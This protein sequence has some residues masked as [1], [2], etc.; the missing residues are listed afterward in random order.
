MNAAKGWRHWKTAP[1]LQ[2]KGCL[3]EDCPLMCASR[4]SSGQCCPGSCRSSRVGP[5]LKTSRIL[6][7]CWQG[8]KMIFLVVNWRE[9]DLWLL[10]LEKSI[11]LPCLSFVS[12]LW[13]QM[14]SGLSWRILSCSLFL[15]YMLPFSQC[16]GKSR[17]I[18][19]CVNAYRK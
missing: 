14:Q 16:F 9:F 15:G 3:T 11:P 10:F 13:G 1:N 2:V 12:F 19:N 5:C 7:S 17:Q 8:S 4:R 18:S 6:Q